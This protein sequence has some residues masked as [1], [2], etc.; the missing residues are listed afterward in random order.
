MLLSELNAETLVGNEQGCLFGVEV[1]A[2]S[3]LTPPMGLREIG[4]I[5]K[6]NSDGDLDD[7][8]LD[9]SISYKLAKVNVMIEIPFA[10]TKEESF[11]KVDL[12][13]LL[14]A[15]TNIGFALSWLPPETDDAKDWDAYT[16]LNQEV[17]KVFFEKAH[18]D[19]MVYPLTSFVEYMVVEQIRGEDV[20]KDFKPTDPY[21]AMRFAQK[22]VQRVSILKNALRETIYEVFGSKLLFEESTATIMIATLKSMNANLDT[23]VLK[24][25]E[26]TA[27]SEKVV[28]PETYTE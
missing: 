1:D 17:A 14:S 15:A 19:Q 12:N 25:K 20:S 6:I 24:E 5:L 23:L 7:N 10:L 8:L 3:T 13:Y 21:I 18:F 26:N 9:V 27:E 4:L 28:N 22:D 16:V 11:K 2:V